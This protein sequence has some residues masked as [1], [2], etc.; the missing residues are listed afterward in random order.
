MEFWSRGEA[1]KGTR[2][3][4]GN[5]RSDFLCEFRILI[6][7]AATV[8]NTFCGGTG[9]GGWEGKAEK[10]A[11]REEKSYFQRKQREKAFQTLEKV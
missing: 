9:G 3:K 2:L 7:D 4:R 11:E 5:N 10:W 1:P 8:K 6:F